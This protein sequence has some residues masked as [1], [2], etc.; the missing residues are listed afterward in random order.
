MPKINPDKI[1]QKKRTAVE[2]RDALADFLQ[3]C[4]RSGIASAVDADDNRVVLNDCIEELLELRQ[5][6]EEV[7]NFVL[8]MNAKMSRR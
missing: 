7:R 2:M 4:A 6:R 3:Q 5:E 1:I 8:T